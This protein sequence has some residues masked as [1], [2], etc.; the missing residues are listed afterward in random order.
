M[1]I[2]RS[3]ARQLLTWAVA[4]HPKTVAELV[5]IAHPA[6]SKRYRLTASGQDLA[7]EI[8]ASA[9]PDIRRTAP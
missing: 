6:V 2:R 5:L 7:D 8:T 9:T 1:R 3:L 4:L